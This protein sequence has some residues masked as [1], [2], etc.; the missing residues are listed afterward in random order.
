[1]FRKSAIALAI[2][3]C[4]LSALAQEG[5]GLDLSDSAEQ[6]PE[7]PPKSGDENAAAVTTSTPVSNIT[8]PTA[9]DTPERKPLTRESL[10]EGERD[11]TVEDRVK[12]VQRKLYM[13][14]GRFE[15]APFITYAVNDPYYM[16]YGLSAQVSWFPADTLGLAVR[17][18]WINVLA[19]EDV[20]TAK[21]TFQSR[22]YYSVP[23]WAGMADIQWSPIY[24]KIAIWN[25][26]WHFDSYL[27]G[28]I[29]VV[30]TETSDAPGRS[31]NPAA[32]LGIGVRFVARDY[33]AFNVAL[34]NTNYVDQPTGTTK[35]ATQNLLALNAG[36]SIF[37][38]F[39]ST[40]QEAQ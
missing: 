6:K 1:M 35:G 39:K 11:V 4:P 22:I 32:D 8:A 10:L 30:R 16:K 18:A 13:K 5:F 9:D 24:G 20:T 36:V 12:S 25:D 27:L 29:G 7:E 2:L 34:I 21:H 14:K 31:L 38:P 40:N 26:I 23:Q 3:L 15:V 33:L 19:T 28:G 37:F 17:G